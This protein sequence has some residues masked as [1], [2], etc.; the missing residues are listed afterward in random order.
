MT[1]PAG[2]LEFGRPQLHGLTTRTPLAS[3][4]F[5]HTLAARTAHGTA[6]VGGQM[7]CRDVVP[8]AT[9]KYGAT[10]VT[11]GG[12]TGR[13][14]DIAGIDITKAGVP[15]DLSRHMQRL[16][17]RPRTIHQLPI[18][19]ECGEMQRHARSE[20]IHY[21]GALR[22]NFITQIVLAWNE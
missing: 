8:I 16:R 1:L 20:P 6:T 2:N 21:P 7:P 5:K 13:I 9:N 4:C 15:S 17:R 11:M 12:L 18:R 19:M 10:C 22:F 14:M 3:N